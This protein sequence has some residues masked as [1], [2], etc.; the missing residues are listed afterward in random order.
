MPKILILVGGF[1]TRLSSVVH[2]VPKPLAPINGKPFLEY[3]LAEIR[4]YFND[5]K[6]Y[7]LTHHLSDKIEAYYSGN[8]R[9]KII[10]EDMPLGTGGAIKNAIKILGLKNK[11]DLLILNGDTYMRPDLYKFIKTSSYNVN[12]LSMRQEQCERSSTILVKDNKVKEFSE[13]GKRKK[14]SYISMGCYYIKDSDFIINN[15]NKNFMIEEE[16]IK[17]SKTGEIGAYFYDDIF[18]DIGIP[19]DYEKMREYIKKNENK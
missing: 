2:D 1:G 9:I 19:N 3:Q 10:K 4:K 12:I 8:N 6:I 16:F 18:I 11:D 7:L 17:Y 15:K 13:Q 5:S 14:D